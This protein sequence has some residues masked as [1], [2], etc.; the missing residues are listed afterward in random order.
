MA[1]LR[2]ELAGYYRLLATRQPRDQAFIKG[3]LTRAYA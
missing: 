2:S 3:W 1:A